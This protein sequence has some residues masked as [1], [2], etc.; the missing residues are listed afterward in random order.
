MTGIHRRTKSTTLRHRLDRLLNLAPDKYLEEDRIP[1]PS[2]GMS[3]LNLTDAIN[4]RLWL[5]TKSKMLDPFAGQKLK[6]L[7]TSKRTSDEGITSN[8]M[9]EDALTGDGVDTPLFDTQHSDPSID[10]QHTFI[11]EKV[12]CGGYLFERLGV[13]EADNSHDLLEEFPTFDEDN[14][15]LFDDQDGEL[16]FESQG[17]LTEED[18][19]HACITEAHHPDDGLLRY[20]QCLASQYPPNN[21]HLY[22]GDKEPPF[23]SRDE[24]LLLESQHELMDEGQGDWGSALDI[25]DLMETEDLEH[26]MLMDEDTLTEENLAD[27]DLFWEARHNEEGMRSKGQGRCRSTMTWGVMEEYSHEL[28]DAGAKDILEGRHELPNDE[29]DNILD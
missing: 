4:A 14:V 19:G 13:L 25:L 24:D 21:Y 18:V 10:N 3:S 1:Y 15:T 29:V 2:S 6:P 8:S 27:G 11:E 20:G 28:L 5:L 26:D 17:T 16:L 22:H 9:L 7:E 12:A 23:D